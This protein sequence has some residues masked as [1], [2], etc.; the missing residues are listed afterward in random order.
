MQ[1]SRL[2][3]STQKDSFVKTS[4]FQ[5]ITIKKRREWNHLHKTCLLNVSKMD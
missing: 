3:K 4:E 1:I 5:V 2:A